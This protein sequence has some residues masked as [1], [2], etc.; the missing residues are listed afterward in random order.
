MAKWF[1]I[2]YNQQVTSVEVL[3][4]TPQFVVYFSP[5]WNKEQREKKDSDWHQTFE[6]AQTELMR[7][8][9]RRMNHAEDDLLKA[10]ADLAIAEGMTQADVVEKV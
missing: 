7:R 5:F 1:K 4:E 8:A 2:G 10:R 6:A 9:N 3:K